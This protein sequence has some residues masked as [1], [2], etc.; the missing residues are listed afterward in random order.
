MN[1]IR[2]ISL[3]TAALGLALS[4]AQAQP[5]L[6]AI[7]SLTESQAGA[8]LDLSGL[9]YSLENGAPANLLGGM[10]S[11][12]TYAGGNTFLALP[13]RGPNAISYNSAVDDTVSYVNRFQTVRMRIDT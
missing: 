2:L 8:N 12:I 11:A 1:K 13:D 6:I 5:T 7:G 3:L 4:L 9:R 10:G